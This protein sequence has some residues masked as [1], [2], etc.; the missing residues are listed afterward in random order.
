MRDYESADGHST[1]KQ[2]LTKIVVKLVAQT[3]HT[4]HSSISL[5]Y[6]FF[7]MAH[8]SKF[9]VDCRKHQKYKF[10]SLFSK[11]TLWNAF[12]I[13]GKME[14]FLVFKKCFC[15]WRQQDKLP[16]FVR[17]VCFCW[18]RADHLTFGPL[19]LRKHIFFVFF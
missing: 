13:L 17:N 1:L 14:K 2:T 5:K 11:A 3:Q 4:S 18:E 12:Q 9:E 10:M 7:F 15:L 8:L 6:N 19:I 16:P